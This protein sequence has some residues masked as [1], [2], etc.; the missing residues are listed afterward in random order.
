MSSTL[1][2]P[3]FSYLLKDSASSGTFSALVFSDAVSEIYVNI[4][5]ACLLIACSVC[6]VTVSNIMSILGFLF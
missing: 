1:L 2:G 5:T 6:S 3:V 4:G